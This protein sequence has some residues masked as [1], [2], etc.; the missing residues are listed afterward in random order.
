M[1]GGVMEAVV[2][3]KRANVKAKCI[4]CSNERLK[5]LSEG[6]SVSGNCHCVGG[7]RLPTV[8]VSC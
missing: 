7:L 8:L 4:K 6:E 1:D 5:Y 3:Q 2:Q